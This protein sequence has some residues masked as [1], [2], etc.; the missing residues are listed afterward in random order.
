MFQGAVEVCADS[1]GLLGKAIAS[2]Q[3]PA[4]TPSGVML[5]KDFFFQNKM[6]ETVKY[7]II[8]I[9]IMILIFNISEQVTFQLS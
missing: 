8:I 5:G 2:I 6:K 9:I 3:I 7:I 1:Y 4:R